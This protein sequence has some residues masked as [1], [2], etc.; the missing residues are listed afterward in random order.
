M[1]IIIEFMNKCILKLCDKYRI[2]K[3]QQISSGGEAVSA[4]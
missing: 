3:N 1:N 2:I 4:R